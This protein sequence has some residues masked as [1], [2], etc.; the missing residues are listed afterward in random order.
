[1]DAIILTMFICAAV[2]SYFGILTIYNKYDK[3][4][5][6]KNTTGLDVARKILDKNKLL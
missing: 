3:I 6:S 1:M 5:N 2:I 4:N